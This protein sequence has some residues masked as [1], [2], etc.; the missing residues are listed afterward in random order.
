MYC[1][2]ISENVPRDLVQFVQIRSC[3]EGLQ[4]CGKWSCLL[5]S[6]LVGNFGQACMTSRNQ[7]QNWKIGPSCTAWPHPTAAIV[8]NMTEACFGQQ[9]DP[10]RFVVLNQQNLKIAWQWVNQ[11]PSA[12]IVLH[13]HD[14]KMIFPSFL[15]GCH[16]HC[17][18]IRPHFGTFI[19]DMWIRDR[20]AFLGRLAWGDGA[21]FCYHT[22]SI[23]NWK[24]RISCWR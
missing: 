8:F 7:K 22:D 20:R 13:T 1:L 18:K 10:L 15:R 3:N 19:Y 17:P 24:Q 16:M 23:D 14:N 6:Y 9:W 5:K 4:S 12:L 2:F 11:I 21:C